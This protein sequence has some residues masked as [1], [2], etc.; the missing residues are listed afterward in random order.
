MMIQLS[1]LLFIT[2]G[3]RL[4]YLLLCTT[5]LYSMLIFLY[6]PN[7]Y[8]R[9][10]KCSNHTSVFDLTIEATLHP[11]LS[12]YVNIEQTTFFGVSPIQL[13]TTILLFCL[14]TVISTDFSQELMP[15][16][17]NG[18]RDEIYEFFYLIKRLA[19]YSKL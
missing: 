19:T 6:Y 7:N 4:L 1:L 11:Q 12:K 17:I 14:H 5:C 16:L 8:S 9:C 15:K 10:F 13:L 2:N 18:M 3:A